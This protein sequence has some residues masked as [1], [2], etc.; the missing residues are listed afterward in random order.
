MICHLIEGLAIAGGHLACKPPVTS[1]GTWLALGVVA[2][3]LIL[4]GHAFWHRKA[5]LVASSLLMIASAD[6][7]ALGSAHPVWHARH[8]NGAAD[9]GLVIA[10]IDGSES[11]WRNE[12]VARAALDRLA[13]E[14]GRIGADP[15]LAEG[16]TA[17]VLGFADTVSALGPAQ[18][19]GRLP[20][21]IRAT[22][23]AEHGAHSRA[24]LG[25]DSALELIGRAGGRGM[26]LMLSDGNFDEPVPPGLLDRAAA[27]GIPI[28]F[29]AVGSP[30]PGA[31]LI[32]ANLG[33]E[34]DIN[35]D[36]VLRGTVLGGGTLMAQA[37][38]GEKT[39]RVVPGASVLQPVRLSARFSQ[40][41]LQHV[42]M[43][44]QSDGGTQ[45]RVLYTLVR[46]PA[47]ILAFGDAPVLD[48]MDPA[49]WVVER[50]S[51]GSPPDPAS[52]DIVVIDSLAP[53]AFPSGYS[54]MLLKA[55]SRTGLFLINGGLRGAVEDRQIIGDWN[56]TPLSPILPVD[57]DPRSFFLE[58]PGRDIVIMIDVSGS[59]ANSLAIAKATARAII[60]RLRP[61]DTVAILPFSDSPGPALDRRNATPQSLA[62]ARAFVDALA[63]GG[64]TAPESTLQKAAG[65]RTNYCAFFFISDA[66]FSPPAT[67]P[68]CFT[69]AISTE[70]ARFPDGVAAWGQEILLHS[71]RG[72]GEI[73]LDY[74]EPEE[75][76]AYFRPETFVPV[77]AAGAGPLTDLRL[78]GVAIA[79]PRVD[80]DIVSL[81]P[82]PP[83]DPVLALRRDR[84]QPAVATGVFLS[85][86][87]ADAPPGD[88][89]TILSALLG[90]S[91]PER[92]DIRV[93]QDRD[94]LTVTVL[95]L[96]DDQGPRLPETLAGSLR[97]EGQGTQTLA[98]RRSGPPGRFEASLSLRPGA[99]P[100]IA[101]LLLA[102][103]GAD[104]QI[105]PA[106]LP[107][108]A[109]VGERR[110][111]GETFDFGVDIENL[112]L[113]A[114]ATGGYDLAESRP[115]LRTA[116]SN[117]VEKP[118][119]ALTICLGLI[120]LALSVWIRGR[121]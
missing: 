81:H 73:R 60:D 49:R 59:M 29:L 75:R 30:S 64:G 114:E 15:A 99:Q 86:L 98:F 2:V 72:I 65:L 37:P 62:V 36:A 14:A 78:P 27:Q 5:A 111:Q 7:L 45:E 11:V 21:L 97:I 25:L 32:A 80:A 9:G 69:T 109:E 95:V 110:G 96:A 40:R 84:D 33:P 113:L 100:A 108:R 34:Q 47:R 55:S 103:P 46:G 12:T 116:L 39:E 22:S 26:I 20:A 50:A 118:L 90:W 16:W 89:D 1:L 67:S 83:P 51:P 101:E 92:Y 38:P 82:D 3:S 94:R 104:V 93:R 115:T 35:S 120:F 4:C 107:G 28:W 66:G 58:P 71:G 85:A 18:P 19:I 24:E 13:D 63:A 44:F 31:G 48:R 41:G 56:E 6:L 10:L 57:S 102:E 68:R 117:P 105:I 106:L 53:A 91:E 17:Q 52:F 88:V 121:P 23:F 119:Q 74:F 112:R 77:P 54:D 76:N 43:T 79:Y 61:Q 42:R 87:P 8:D 70:G